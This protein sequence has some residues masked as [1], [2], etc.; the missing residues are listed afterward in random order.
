MRFIHRTIT[1]IAAVGCLTAAAATTSA[2]QAATGARASVTPPSWVIQPTPAVS[3]YSQMREVSCAPDSKYCVAVG[4]LGVAKH[5]TER[6]NGAAWAPQHTPLPAGASSAGLGSVSCPKVDTC[7]A[8]GSYYIK[9]T[10]TTMPLVEQWNGHRWEVQSAPAVSGGLGMVSCPAV[11]MCMAIGGTVAAEW[12]GSSWTTQTISIPGGTLDALSCPDTTDCMAVGND[13]PNGNLSELWNGTDWTAEPTAG[14]EPQDIY[15]VSCADADL[16][17]A[18]GVII[19]GSET[20]AL[21][22]EWNGT[23]W[24]QSGI[25]YIQNSYLWGVSCPKPRSC[26]AVGYDSPESTNVAVPLAEQWNGKG[27]AMETPPNPP[28]SESALLLSVSCSDAVTC[29]AVGGYWD[30]SLGYY[31][32]LAEGR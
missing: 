27:W 18:V 15:D 17:W 22:E 26:T 12:N 2:A 10:K 31:Q 3:K 7:I 11:N 5:L 14:D 13:E 19:P 8:V 32:Q 24:T 9:A 16:C 20:V 25:P 21:V 1:L 29:T 23:E 6:W 30:E 4:D 28:D